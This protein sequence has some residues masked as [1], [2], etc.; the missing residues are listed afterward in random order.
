[1]TP[2]ELHFIESNGEEAQPVE[3]PSNIKLTLFEVSGTYIKLNYLNDP[4]NLTHLYQGEL[5]SFVM[6][7][8]SIRDLK[9]KLP[10][11]SYTRGKGF[12]HMFDQLKDFY[13]EQLQRR[14][15]KMV[16]GVESVRVALN[17][18]KA[19][20]GMF[21]EPIVAIYQGETVY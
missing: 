19:F 13:L 9:I 8:T 12:D 17:I 10:L 3:R 4:C 11:F 5:L 15:L 7:I 21:Q 2:D 1:M 16:T 20:V 14:S 6:N 18:G